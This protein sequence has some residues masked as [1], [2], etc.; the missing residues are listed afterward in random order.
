M[1][2]QS[3]HH[4]IFIKLISLFGKGNNL[5][6]KWNES[7]NCL[8]ENF[9][10]TRRTLNYKG[11]GLYVFTLC[12]LLQ[13]AEWHIFQRNTTHLDKIKIGISLVL[14]ISA[15]AHAYAVLDKVPEV[16]LCTNGHLQILEN[17]KDKCGT[18]SG[19]TSLIW[20]LNLLFVFGIYLGATLCPPIHVY[21][22]HWLNPC[23]PSLLGY[24]LIPTCQGFKSS[25]L[26]IPVKF[27]I[28]IFNHVILQITSQWLGYVIAVLLCLET[29]SLVECL[30]LF[31]LRWRD[32]T[33]IEQVRSCTFYRELQLLGNLNNSIKQKLITSS[34]LINGILFHAICFSATIFLTKSYQAGENFVSLA[35]FVLTA[36]DCFMLIVVLFGEMS[37]V[38]KESKHILENLKRHQSPTRASAA[39]RYRK[40]WQRKFFRSC[41]PLSVKF[42]ANNFVDELTPLNSLNFS[43]GLVVQ[44]LLLRR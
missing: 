20:R 22:F 23:L 5:P 9:D 17:C 31:H 43:W 40:V 38:H 16:I 41:A 24:W 32:S 33:E 35:Y 2:L 4:S 11:Y 42:G 7:T 21:L 19:D 36:V 10:T 44:L 1:Q 6:V 39:S 18:N 28:L 29:M 14:F 15:S 3:R 8:T 30:K 12:L 27:G 37:C 25:N 13:I 34:M 26:E